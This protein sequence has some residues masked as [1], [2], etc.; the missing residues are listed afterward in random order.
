MKLNLAVKP[1]GLA[2]D[3]VLPSCV[4]LDEFLNSFVPLC[5]HQ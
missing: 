1:Q 4:T 2:F 5:S 3:I